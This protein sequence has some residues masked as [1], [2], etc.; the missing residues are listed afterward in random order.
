MLNPSNLNVVR[1]VGHMERRTNSQRWSMRKLIGVVLTAVMV[2]VGGGLPSRLSAADSAE[3]V[4]EV[5]QHLI[6]GEYGLAIEKA[7]TIPDEKLR[8]AELR[9][10]SLRQEEAGDF[11]TA[12]ATER[13]RSRQSVET[14]RTQASGGGQADPTAIMNLIENLTGG[15][16]TGTWD[17]EEV[18]DGADPPAM[19][20]F[21]NGV[22]VDPHGILSNLSRKDLTDRLDRLGILARNAILNPAQNQQNELRF[23]SL[24]RLEREVADRLSRGQEL[25]AT[26]KY[27]GG[28]T[29]V[30]YLFILPEQKE[31]VVAG[32]AEAWKYDDNGLAVGV[33]S[34]RPLLQ[35]DDLVVLLRTFGTAENHAFGCSIDPRP[36]NLLATKQYLSS[37]KGPLPPGAM[38]GWLQQIEKHMGLQDIRI[39]GVPSSSRVAN[40]MV[41]ADYRMKLIG[42][43]KMSAG[44][45]I[46]DIFKLMAKSK[47]QEQLPLQAFRWWLTMKYDAVLHNESRNVYEIKGSSV[48]VKSEDQMISSSGKQLQAGNANGAN[49]LFAENFSNHYEELAR[50]DTVFADLQNIFDLGMVAAICRREHLADKIGWDFG[51]FA[52]SGRY[53]PQALRAPTSVKTVMSH[54]VS[55]GKNIL[56]QAAGGVQVNL[57]RAIREENLIQSSTLVKSLDT[58]G[59]APADQPEGRWWWNESR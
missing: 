4:K 58:E 52:A 33:N 5:K 35:L 32:P 26:M 59:A 15:P 16:K 29:G 8:S 28:L 24:T 44:P 57:L 20:Y 37:I 45:S 18:E 13:L 2:F 12:R 51:E 30:K 6:A 42:I 27:L 50:R 53:Q 11:Q 34:G 23:V 40:V 48:L 1:K 19:E 39:Y 21:D 46:P 49:R 14:E 55:G 47:D 41:T 36:E 43:G 3:I 56:V 31:L 7:Q 22:S 9:E 10:I 25:T 38:T 54:R 17:A